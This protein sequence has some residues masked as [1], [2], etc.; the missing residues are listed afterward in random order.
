[1]GN[2]YARY[3]YYSLTGETG[4]CLR[5]GRNATTVYPYGIISKPYTMLFSNDLSQ[6][7][8]YN[9]ITRE[10]KHKR[11]P[12]LYDERACTKNRITVVFK[13]NPVRVRG[14]GGAPIVNC[15]C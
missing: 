3:R 12:L 9:I 1:M 8:V 13:A 14:R 4:V 11:N 5:G 10:A 7:R 6:N 15:R 2:K